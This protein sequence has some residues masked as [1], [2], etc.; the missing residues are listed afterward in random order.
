MSGAGATAGDL[1][2]QFLQDRVGKRVI[3]LGRNHERA[4]P[5]DD[6]IVVIAVEIRLERKDRQAVDADAIGDRFVARRC[7]GASAIIAAIARHVDD[8]AAAAER[9]SGEKHP[10]IIDRAADR[11]A[12]AEQL[13]PRIFDRIG[14]RVHTSRVR[15]KRPIDGLHMQFRTGPLHHGDRDRLRA[16]RADRV[17]HLPIAKRRG[18]ALLLQFEAIVAD[19]AG[20]VHREHERE[21][22]LALHRTRRLRLLLRGERCCGEQQQ[23]AQ[24]GADHACPDH[25]EVDLARSRSAR[26]PS[27]PTP[28]T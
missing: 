13:S 14:K 17:Q 21:C 6:I 7:H 1:A 3:V 18:V 4:R 15:D 25:G 16:Q 23:R 12:A 22:D 9:G 24:A 8:A 20:S 10:R 26:P 28:K 11:G 5:A 2:D 27:A 19:A